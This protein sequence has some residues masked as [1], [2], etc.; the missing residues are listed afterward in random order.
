M[1][2]N[3]FLVSIVLFFVL[4]SVYNI[5]AYQGTNVLTVIVY[6]SDRTTPLP[7]AIVKLYEVVRGRTSFLSQA[8]T[9]SEGK[10]SFSGL[11]D[12][13]Y[14]VKV[15]YRGKVVFPKS[16]GRITLERGLMY[17]LR[18]YTTLGKGA[19][20]DTEVAGTNTLVF[21]VYKSDGI[22]PISGA[23]VKLYKNG[24]LVITGV[25]DVNGRVAFF[26]LPSTGL[27]E[28]YTPEVIYEGVTIFPT[29]S[30]R[31]TLTGGIM[32]R[33]TLITTLG[34]VTHE[35]GRPITSSVELL[36]NV[37]QRALGIIS[38]LN[39]VSRNILNRNMSRDAY[40][41]QLIA[42]KAESETLLRQ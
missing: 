24:R 33:Y 16:M 35:E 14:A 23:F 13:N 28:Y 1:R 2:N 36:L 7:G 11:A 17:T 42:I 8:R 12:G 9:N 30:L 6:Y 31:I 4:S 3:K 25:S 37:T 27:G 34:K 15:V 10:A 22:T 5:A 20:E 26:N 40:L 29:N 41:P 19:P 18:V 21:D 32:G 38:H 39:N